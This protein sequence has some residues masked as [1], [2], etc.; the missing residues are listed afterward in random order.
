MVSL[1]PLDVA[2]DQGADAA[3]PL[4]AIEAVLMSRHGAIFIMGWIDDASDGLTCVRIHGA[5][6]RL[7]FSTAALVRV[8][9]G[10]IATTL[11]ID[12]PRT[13]GFWAIESDVQTASDGGRL[14]NIVSHQT[15]LLEFE[16]AS[17]VSWTL[18]VRVQ[19]GEDM[20]LRDTALEFLGKSR[21][22]GNDH[23]EAFAALDSFTGAA[24]L[25]LNARTIGNAIANPYVQRFGSQQRCTSSIVVCL[26]GKPEFQILQTTL[27]ADGPGMGD[28]EL[29]YICNSPEDGE[30]LMAQARIIEITKGVA[31]TVILLPANAG[32]GPANNVA[33]QYCRSDRII[34]MNPD[35]FPRGRDWAALHSQAVEERPSLET[36]LFGVPL[37][38]DDGSLMHGGMYFEIDHGLQARPDGFVAHDLVRV[39][40]YG[41]GTDPK[42]TGFA[43]RRPVPAVTGAFMSTRRAWFE[44]LGGFSESYIFGHYEDADL[45]LKSIATG[46]V[47]WVQAVPMW[48]LEGKGG[49]RA[50]LHDGG[51]IVNR[52]Q[53]S[54][55]WAPAIARDMV[56]SRPSNIRFSGVRPAVDA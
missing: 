27:M 7:N 48:H 23:V 51:A 50:A 43:A 22:C 16:L 41:K 8:Q 53:F 9:R 29:V 39:E 42:V 37:Y 47:P 14:Q 52:W 54:R 34:F 31:Q 12:L 44:G 17:G 13:L 21:F 24:F 40:H 46:V 28:Y 25:R 38:Y 2:Q 30:K 3:V 36:D 56:G 11:G 5:G 33:A 4:H 6:W 32:F 55:Q 10:D 49:T 20:A 18:R 26:Y 1:S 35:V 19:I 15:C 45:C